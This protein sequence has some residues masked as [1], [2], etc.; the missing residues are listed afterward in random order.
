MA[1]LHS[2]IQR[3]R[4][5]RET[6]AQRI[7]RWK[8]AERLA[9]KAIG[10]IKKPKRHKRRKKKPKIDYQKY[11]HSPKWFAF[12]HGI[13]SAR[14]EKCEDCGGFPVYL[15]H[16]TYKRLGNEIPDDVELLCKPCHQRRHPYKTI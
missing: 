13:I 7:A 1:K 3:N 16:K 12:R 5:L 4:W 9:L 10:I 6:E 11:I 15:H 8:E 14:G 2:T